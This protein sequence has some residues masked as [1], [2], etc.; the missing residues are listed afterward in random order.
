MFGPTFQTPPTHEPV[1]VIRQQFLHLLKRR[2]VLLGDVPP[3][4]G[5]SV[6]GHALEGTDDGLQAVQV[7]HIVQLLHFGRERMENGQI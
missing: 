5:Q 6:Y 7:V 1:I 4:E 2:F 3:G